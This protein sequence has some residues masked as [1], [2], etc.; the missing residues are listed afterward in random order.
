MH[1]I[2][3]AETQW[4]DPRAVPG[5]LRSENAATDLPDEHDSMH[6]LSNANGL[7]LKAIERGASL[8]EFHAP[9][10][11][12]MLSDILLG[13]ASPEDYR[14]NPFYFGSVV[15]RCANRIAGGAFSLDGAAYTLATNNGPNHLH[16]G[17]HGFSDR[18]W[19]VS[20]PADPRGAALRF[21][22]TSPDGEEGYPG[23]LH[24]RV[25]YVLTDADELIVEMEATA[26][27][28][29]LCNLVQHA[30]WNLSG[31]PAGGPVSSIRDHEVTLFA[32]RYT[33]TDATGIPTGAST[34]VAGTPFDFSAPK[35]LGRDLERVGDDPAGYDTNYVIGGEPGVVRPVARVREPG[36]GRVMTLA[37]DQAGVQL[38]TGNFLDGRS[39]GKG[40]DGYARHA[41]F[42]LETQS[43]PDAINRPSWRQPVLRPGETYRHT[44]VFAFSTDRGDA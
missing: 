39:R 20:R 22:R 10:R 21:E 23:T 24:A 44:M 43:F 11:D 30:Y 33:P 6:T 18:D 34:P 5:G 41:G 15:G 4:S 8:T 19:D 31:H 29:T 17:A 27:A 38:Y 16:G 7:I 9:D 42:C 14:D 35:P 32:D 28:P 3:D 2:R 12:G 1:R 13:L 25:S 40:G 26:D 37:S 36:S